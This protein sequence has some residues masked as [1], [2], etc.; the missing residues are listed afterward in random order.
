MFRVDPIKILTRT[1]IRQIIEELRRKRRSVNTRLNLV[2]FRLSTCCGL[3]VSE[4]VGL[5]MANLKLSGQRPH[6][7]LPA[8]IGK[9]KKARRVPLW[10][11]GAN[12]A[13][14][15]QWRQ[16]RIDQGAKAGD[17]F[18]CA[19]S[20][21][22]FG[23]PLSDRNAQ[24]RWKSAIKV[25]G[26]ERVSMLSI[27]CGRHSF[28]SHALAGGRSLAE[29]RDAAGHSNISTTSIYAHVVSDEDEGVG[30]LFAF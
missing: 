9:G 19:Q 20:S 3:R 4:I 24:H 17:P 5:K 22:A 25:L 10:W 2:I 29:T 8:A 26:P 1:E 15:E 30:D 14:L 11:C 23:K 27:H 12:L 16:E 21:A 28:V 13:N 7:Q 6:I 18:V